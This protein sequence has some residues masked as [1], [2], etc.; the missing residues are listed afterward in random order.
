MRIIFR[1]YRYPAGISED[2]YLLRAFFLKR[3]GDDFPFGRWDWMI[4]HGWM[5]HEA[6]Q[7][8]GIWEDD[9]EIVGVATFDTRPGEG[10]ICVLRGYE[11]LQSDMIQYAAR[12]LTK[13]NRFRL[14]VPD[15]DPDFQQ[16][17]AQQRFAPTSEQEFD[18]AYDIREP[19]LIHYPLA[20]G[21]RIT[22]MAESYDVEKYGQILWKGFNHE[23]NGEGPLNLSAAKRRQLDS[24]MIRPHVDLSLK[25]A[26]VA[27]NGDYAAYCGMWLDAASPDALVEPVATDPEYRRLG[28]GRAVVLEGVRR[29]GLRGAKRALVGSNQPF[30]YKIGFVPLNT[31]TWWTQRQDAGAEC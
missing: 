22:S 8:I 3:R 25:I 13:D 9:G 20:P 28:L 14:L 2:Y 11:F 16:T 21:F 15:A 19:D 23:I 1:T 26:V 12:N 31:Y 27:P 7:R 4:T 6:L 29:C 24:E 30:Y 18:A 10:F 5:D 17:A